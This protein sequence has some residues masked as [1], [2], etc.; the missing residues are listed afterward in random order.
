MSELDAQLE[1]VVETDAAKD[2]C[3]GCEVRAVP[4]GRR[5][6]RVRDLPYGGRPVTLVWLKRLWR[7]PEPAREVWT[8]SRQRPGQEGQASIGHGF[9]NRDNY[10]LRV[11]LVTGWTGQLSP[12][13]LPLPPRSEDAHHAWWRR[14]RLLGSLSWP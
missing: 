12:G 10:R 3:A 9:R 14:A 6:T 7:C 4:H 1:Q 2:W 5:R 11:L 8:W 13:R